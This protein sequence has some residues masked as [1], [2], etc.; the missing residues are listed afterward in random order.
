MRMARLHPEA[1]AEA[2]SSFE[3][4][5][6][7]NE[8]AALRFLAELDA[9]IRAIEEA[10]LRWPVFCHEARRYRFDRFPYALIY[11]VDEDEVFIVAVAHSS[12]RPGYWLS[13]R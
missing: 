7:R 11:F 3:W 5:R 10:P 8:H 1:S 13:R 4:Y 9:A 12:R 2:D 6:A